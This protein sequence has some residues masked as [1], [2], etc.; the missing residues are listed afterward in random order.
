M[1]TAG[2]SRRFRD[3]QGAAHRNRIAG[4]TFSLGSFSMIGIPITMGFISKYL[5]ALAGFRGGILVV[6]TLIALAV[7]TVLNTFY[8]ARTVIPDFFFGLSIF[9][10]KRRVNICRHTRRSERVCCFF[11]P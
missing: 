5:F 1:V 8:F 7:S 4:L 11:T 6:P 9:E 10:K 2:G 3:L